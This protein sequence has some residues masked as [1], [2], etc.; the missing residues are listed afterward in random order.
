LSNGKVVLCHSP[1][2][3]FTPSLLKYFEGAEEGKN[4]S[5]NPNT[6]RIQFI[7]CDASQILKGPNILAY[8]IK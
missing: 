8:I 1:V 3:D 6:L 2:L 4:C 5:T 7:S